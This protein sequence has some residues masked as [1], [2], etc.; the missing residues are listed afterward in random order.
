[1]RQVRHLLVVATNSVSDSVSVLPAQYFDVALVDLDGVVYRGADPVPHAAQ[2]L[3]R[4]RD[5]GMTIAYVTNNAARTPQEVAA[6]LTELGAPAQPNQVI[7]SAQAGA[8]LIRRTLGEGS[9]RILAVGG[10]GVSAALLA[11]GLQPIHSADDGPHAVLQGFGRNVSWT[12]L[13]EVATAVG[14]GVTWVATNPDTSIPTPRGHS[15]GNGALVQAVSLATGREPDFVAGKPY[16]PLMEDSIAR[17]GARL[18]LVIGDRL[19]TDIEA[20]ISTGVSSLLVFTGIASTLEVLRAPVFQRPHF[21][22]VDLRSMFDEH[23]P[24]HQTPVGWQVGDARAQIVGSPAQVQLWA[25]LVTCAQWASAFRLLCHVAW[26][27]DADYST[28]L[29]QLQGA[30]AHLGDGSAR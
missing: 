16:T 17:T 13:D 21:V 8:N 10:P 20:A 24:L 25:P 28:A 19:D 7:T 15:P 4:A 1:M 30:L 29:A 11:E 27:T 5:A 22:G 23:P 26:S 12:D 6:H 3:R 9:W 18:P 2:A 14:R